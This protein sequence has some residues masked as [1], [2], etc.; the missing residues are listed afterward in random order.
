[1]NKLKKILVPIYLKLYKI[2]TL[3]IN[4]YQYK[5]QNYTDSFVSKE[6]KVTDLTLEKAKEVIYIF[7]TGD[8]EI[9]ENRKSGIKSLKEKAEVEIVLVT[10]NNLSNYILKDYP[11][12]EAYEYL[13]LIHKSDYLRCYFMLHHGGGYADIK[14]SLTSWKRLFEQLNQAPKHWCIGPREIYSGGVPDLEGNIGID[15]KKYH[16]LLIGNCGYIFKPNSP[17]AQEWMNEVNSRLDKLEQAL[18]KNPGNVYGDNIGY[19]VE[20]SF[21]LAQVFHPI[22]LKYSEHVFSEDIILYDTVNYR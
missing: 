21:I 5:K 15:I 7:W 19:P 9:S 3:Y 4:T 18:I 11:L 10:P 8:N 6:E 13:S 17:I 20:W 14:P 12:H 2:Y 16:N 22:I 1:M